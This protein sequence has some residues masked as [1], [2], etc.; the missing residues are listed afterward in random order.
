MNI[1]QLAYFIG[2]GFVGALLYV[3]RNSTS[4]KDFWGFDSVKRYVMG[5]V[6]GGIYDVLYS[7]YNFPNSIMC[8]I[9]GYSGTSFI[10][11]II[12]KFQS[13]PTAPS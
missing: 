12:T 1:E 9:A 7:D 6:I 8:L 11:W 10:D 5:I 4:Y 3:L 13:E 2:L